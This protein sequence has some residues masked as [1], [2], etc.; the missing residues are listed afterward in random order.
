MRI[1]TVDN[2][3]TKFMEFAKS[4]VSD[5]SISEERSD[6][7]LFPID[8]GIPKMLSELEKKKEELGVTS[9]SFAVQ[10]LEDML[11][12]LIQAEEAKHEG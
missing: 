7:I 9:Y 3:L 5:I 1:N 2:D 8:S 4:F 11:L 10:Q 12:K 6:T